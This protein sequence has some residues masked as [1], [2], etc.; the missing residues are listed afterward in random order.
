MQT[1]LIN[2]A[3]VDDQTL[4]RKTLKAYLSE[5]ANI[6]V[7]AQSPSIPELL[8][9]LKNVTVNVLLMD[10][11]IPNL[12]GVPAVRLIKN[13]YPDI[14]ILVLT[15][16]A[17]MELLSELL[18]EG[19]YGILSKVD[20][21]EELIMAIKSISENRIY[22]SKLFTEVMYWNKQINNKRFPNATSTMLL[23]EREKNILQLLWEEKT[24]KEIAGCLFLSIRSIEKIRQDMKEKLGVKST[25]GLLK[26]FV[27]EVATTSKHVI[28]NKVV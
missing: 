20:E 13:Q 8:T 6:N 21:P 9:D 17:D 26:Y 18:E 1:K 5:H 2:L 14:K 16:C 4:F 10:F 25:V 15:M 19:V 12:S 3:I 11:F 23:T 24:N 27:N 22:R 28:G 7:V